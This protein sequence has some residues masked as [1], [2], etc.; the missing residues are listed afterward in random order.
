TRLR[1]EP[2]QEIAR[3]TGGLYLPARNRDIRLGAFF[4][5]VL[6]PRGT[7]T[8]SEVE[9]I[10]GLPIPKQ[11]YAWFLGAALALFAGSMLISDRYRSR[12]RSRVPAVL[13][14]IPLSLVL[15]SAA[16]PKPSTPPSPVDDLI[17]KGNA[18]YE[19]EEFSNA[20]KLY[21][22]AEERSLDP[23][24]VAFNKAAALYRL[25]RY[26]E[27]AEHFQ[28]AVEDKQAPPLRQ[29][30]GYYDLGNCFV[31]AKPSDVKSLEQAVHSYRECL[32]L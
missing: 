15:V 11:Q 10:A 32:A 1:E 19:K 25:E 16:P 13:W 29:A 20:L 31:K 2:L 24:L 5:D 8:A 14:L 17:Q 4:R 27:A 21:Q 22:Q 23:G 18:A 30:R 6:E 7:R 9:S 26:P 12:A 28:R 3:Q